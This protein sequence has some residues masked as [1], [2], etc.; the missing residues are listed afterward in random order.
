MGERIRLRN[1]N[2]GEIAYADK[3]RVYS[4][5]GDED[6]TSL[7]DL[8]LVWE[9]V[10]V[11]Y[12]IDALGQVQA[13]NTGWSMEPYLKNFGNYFESKE[14]AEKAVKRLRAWKRLKDRNFRVN[15]N[16]STGGATINHKD[17]IMC[18]IEAYFDDKWEEGNM[19]AEEDL[20]LL[21]GGEE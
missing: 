13:M 12:M 6:W 4:K 15:L 7:A 19:K 8:S 3:I 20:D 17:V 2:T 16:Y 5:D 18:R 14:E 1:K 9:E 10:G 21:L 11:F